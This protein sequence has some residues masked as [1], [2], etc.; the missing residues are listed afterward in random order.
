MD[1]PLERRVINDPGR[2]DSDDVAAGERRRRYSRSVDKG[3][4]PAFL[5]RQDRVAAKM[6]KSRMPPGNRGVI[7]PDFILWQPSD[8]NRRFLAEKEVLLS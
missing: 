7:E 6:S 4:V 8:A 5:V 1:G 2:A 3:S